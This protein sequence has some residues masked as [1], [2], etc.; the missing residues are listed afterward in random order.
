MPEGMSSISGHNQPSQAGTGA[1]LKSLGVPVFYSKISGGYLANTKYNLEERPGHVDVDI[2]L[3]FSVEDLKN[4][5]ADEIQDKM[6]ELGYTKIIRD[7]GATILNPGCGS[8]FG[9]HEGLITPRDV[10]VSTTNRNFPGR[11]GSMK[12]QIYLASPATAA[13]C[14]LTGEITVPEV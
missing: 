3:M 6:D 5:S 7:A 14:A 4:M 10:C 13:A 9:A 2:D 1:L 11:M 8:C 12:G